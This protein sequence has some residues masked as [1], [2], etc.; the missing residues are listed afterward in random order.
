MHDHEHRGSIASQELFDTVSNVV[1]FVREGRQVR[2]RYRHNMHT[3]Y[4]GNN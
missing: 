4:R 2:H 3:R 1:E